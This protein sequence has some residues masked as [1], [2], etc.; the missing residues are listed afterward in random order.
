M[1][2]VWII[3]L[4]IV[5]VI[6]FIV[7]SC[8]CNPTKIKKKAE[9]Q[10]RQLIGPKQIMIIR[11]YNNDGGFFW[12]IY[13]ILN[14]LYI[15]NMKGFKPIV[16]F[17]T[18]LYFE[19]RKEFIKDMVVYDKDN[20]FNHFFE[21]INESDQS[22]SFWITYIQ[23]NKIPYYEMNKVTY[24]VMLFDRVTLKSIISSPG[25][26]QSYTNMWHKYIKILPHITNKITA[27]KEKYWKGCDH[28]IGMH[29]RG[30]DKL[31]SSSGDEDGPIHVEYEFCQS[32]IK[33]YINEHKDVVKTALFIA[34]DEQ[35][36]IDYIAKSGLPITVTSTDSIRA[37]INTSGLFTK[38]DTSMC[39]KGKS[40]NEVCKKFNELIDN[41][42][43]RGFPDRSKY[44]KGE[45]VLIDVLLLSQSNAFYR[46]RG[47]VSNFIAYINPKTE[48][49]DMV[50]LYKKDK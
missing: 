10:V 26:S 12:Q 13:N 17:D 2:Y 48:I 42:V 4:V 8:T 43:H 37:T 38:T 34:S 11:N 39:A 15:C 23:N 30:T 45:D 28:I 18:G 32:L 9:S 50:N 49:L 31:P 1:F 21:P 24:P 44:I 29:F 36:F 25:R 19:K 33:N 27:F 14:M 6:L 20:W 47:N 46:S 3:A 7:I 5:A 40:Q 35:P 22:Q 16:L 41:S